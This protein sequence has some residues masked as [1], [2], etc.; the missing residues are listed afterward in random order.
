MSLCLNCEVELGEEINQCPLC[1][2]KVG[3][4]TEKERT[5][6]AESYPSDILIIHKK[7]LRKRIWELTGVITFSAIIVCTIVDLETVKGLKWSLYADTAILGSWICLSLF[8]MAFR[9]FFIIIPGLFFTVLTCLL[10]FNL[11]SPPVSWFFP[12][13][14]PLTVSFFVLI[15]CI[16]VLWKVAHFKGFNILAFAF[17]LLSGFCIVTELFVDKYL[18]SK[19]EIRWSAIVAVSLLPIELILLFIHYRMK[20]GKRLD[21]Y[22]HI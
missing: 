16:Y 19:V 13:G 15:S 14:L 18:Y 4:V 12:V 10:L 21:S 6:P 2:T 3:E 5:S 22:F 1:G 7:E 20:R 8:L 17:L 9:K 11:I